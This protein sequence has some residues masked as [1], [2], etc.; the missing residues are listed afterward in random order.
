MNEWMLNE[1]R[2]F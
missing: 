1:K 2:I